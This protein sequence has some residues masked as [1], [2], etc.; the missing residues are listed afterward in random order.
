MLS[1]STSTST[2]PFATGG[3]GAVLMDA[4]RRARSLMVSE[5]VLPFSLGATC[6]DLL[7]ELLVLDGLSPLRCVEQNRDALP[8]GA[9]YGIAL[10]DARL[11]HERT[12][13]A[14]DLLERLARHHARFLVEGAGRAQ[15]PQ[16]GIRSAPQRVDRCAR[17]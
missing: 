2:P 15:Q 11:E 8:C 1:S 4:R 16:G 6:D 5:P 3:S 13:D 9:P 14:G 7:G 12:E 17:A 10:M